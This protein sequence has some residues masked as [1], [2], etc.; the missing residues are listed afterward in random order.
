[1]ETMIA[2]GVFAIGFVAVAS[3]FPVAT[4]LQKESVE[5]VLA[6][7]VARNAAA[8]IQ[9]RKFRHDELNGTSS[10]PHPRRIPP[11]DLR[12]YSLH[13][14]RGG[15][16]SHKGQFDHWR[17]N[18]RSYFFVMRDDVGFMKNIDI[19]YAPNQTQEITTAGGFD[20]AEYNRS[21]YWVP[22]IRRTQIPT[23][24]DDWQV[25]VFVL[26]GGEEIYDTSG[27][28]SDPAR[29]GAATNYPSWANLDGFI[30]GVGDLRVPGVNRIPVQVDPA[31]ADRFLFFSWNR[32]RYGIDQTSAGEG[33]M[34]DTAFEVNAGDLVLDNNGTI[35]TVVGADE[36][37]IRVAGRIPRTPIAPD[38]LYYGRP[39][40]E[41]RPS[42][43]KM[44]IT[45][46]DAVKP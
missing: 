36:G 44:I 3:I 25:F 16:T 21:Y 15:D 33:N 23:T 43:T 40:G 19:R 41:G 30:I 4:A 14:N 46:R 18:D 26:R 38:A 11:N 35:H 22:L 24:P 2:L 10:P 17:L 8:L 13:G 20:P 1:M 42:P 7:Q 6:Q 31:N 27:Y 34:S 28:T 29:I 45:V 12:V 39:A 32:N 9:G 37:G 5:D